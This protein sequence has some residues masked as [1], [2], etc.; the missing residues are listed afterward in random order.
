[1][2]KLSRESGKAGFSLKRNTERQENEQNEQTTLTA[3]QVPRAENNATEIPATA[4]PDVQE[5][6]GKE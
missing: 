4:N 2:F 1:M 6:R 3:E 5:T